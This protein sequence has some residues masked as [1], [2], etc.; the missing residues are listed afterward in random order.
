MSLEENR[1]ASSS[2]DF[3]LPLSVFLRF[4]FFL[5]NCLKVL[6]EQLRLWRQ[7]EHVKCCIRTEADVLRVAAEQDF[8]QIF[9]GVLARWLFVVSG[10]VGPVGEAVASDECDNIQV[11]HVN[12]STLDSGIVRLMNAYYIS[13]ILPRIGRTSS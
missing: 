13:T 2:E 8:D 1:V 7:L 11:V 5:R 6:G 12:S 10:A 4:P 9:F 3:V